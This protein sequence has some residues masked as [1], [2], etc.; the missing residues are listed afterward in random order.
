RCHRVSGIIGAYAGGP[1][2]LHARAAG[3][4]LRPA[5]RARHA[6]PGNWIRAFLYEGLPPMNPGDEPTVDPP[7]AGFARLSLEIPSGSITPPDTLLQA[8]LPRGPVSARPTPA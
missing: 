3:R 4:P 1:R 2:T 5:G 7:S 6:G 8:A